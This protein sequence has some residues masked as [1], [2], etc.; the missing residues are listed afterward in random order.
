[1]SFAPYFSSLFRPSTT[2]F[3]SSLNIASKATQSTE[4]ATAPK[5][6]QAFLQLCALYIPC[7]HDDYDDAVLNLDTEVS[8]NLRSAKLSLEFV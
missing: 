8:I 1:M 2:G 7:E 5:R 6:V 3:P 4:K